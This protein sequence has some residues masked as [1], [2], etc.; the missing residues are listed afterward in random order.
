MLKKLSFS[1]AMIPL[2][3]FAGINIPGIEAPVTQSNI[4]DKE[5]AKRGLS[6]YQDDFYDDQNLNNI[7]LDTKALHEAKVWGLS[8]DEEKRYLAL[9]ANR[10]A[11]FYEGLH[12]TPLDIL[13]INARNE[14]ERVHFAEMLAQ[15][16]AQKTVQNLAWNSAFHKA[17]NAL[18]KDVPVVGDDFDP[19]PFSPLNHK[20][21]VL[22][23]QDE[24]YLFIKPDDAAVSIV[25][26]LKDAIAQ[27]KDTKLNL[28]MLDAEALDIQ[29]FATKVGL[30]HELVKAQRITL[31]QGDLHYKNLSVV[32]KKTPLLLLVRNGF[33]TVVNL[34]KF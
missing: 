31:N 2:I 14:A 10:S 25:M 29:H 1:L 30:S 28:M 7:K 16:E 17:Y 24:L 33:S 27:T 11:V 32:D 21:L 9:M 20:P 34:G 19:R 23:A 18:F 5:I 15:M 4:A 26:M 3:S 12:L 22:N 8:E 6:F 13:G